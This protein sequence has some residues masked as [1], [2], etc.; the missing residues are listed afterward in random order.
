[1]GHLSDNVKYVLRG[2]QACRPGFGLAA[3]AAKNLQNIWFYDMRCN[4]TTEIFK[5]QRGKG[6]HFVKNPF[7][8]LKKEW[9]YLQLE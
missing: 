3:K 2:A 9:L 4:Y 7:K 5:M 6:K 1:M 8:F